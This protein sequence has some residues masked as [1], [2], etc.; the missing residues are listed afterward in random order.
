VV[1][2]SFTVFL[3]R[4]SQ[5][6][7]S[8]AVVFWLLAA[9]LLGSI[10]IARLDLLVGVLVGVGVVLAVQRP[11]VAAALLSIATGLKLWPVLVLPGLLGASRHRARSGS[12]VVVLGAALAGGTV[13]AAG[14]DRLL[15]PLGYQSA[16]GLQVESVLAT[17]LMAVW[18]FGSDA[19]HVEYAASRSFEVSG[20][21]AGALLLAST[22]LTG[23]LLLGFILL[24][25]RVL[26]GNRLSVAGLVW[27]ALA[28]TSG[29]LVC[30]KVLSPQYLLW[31]LPVVAAGLAVAPSRPLLRWGIALLA[32]TA[33]THVLYPVLYPGLV[34]REGYTWLAVTVLVVRNIALVVLTVAAS[35]RAWAGTGALSRS[36]TVPAARAR[37]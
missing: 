11:R 9:P 32:V 2:A 14:W 10:S 22:L 19:W 1:D 21:G 23:G 27:F 3:H 29:F 35:V 37:V 36:D 30:S 24:S 20:P 4:S 34:E 12:V 16:R 33:L 25:V 17:P 6:G 13:L 18:A 8:A 7:D 5:P 31:V 26:R 15:S 28:V